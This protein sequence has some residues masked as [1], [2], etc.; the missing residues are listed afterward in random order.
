MED[1]NNLL[2]HEKGV[3]NSGEISKAYQYDPYS[4]DDRCSFVKWAGSFLALRAAHKNYTGADI[5]PT[6]EL[7]YWAKQTA[8]YRRN[9]VTD[10]DINKLAQK[11][12]DWYRHHGKY[13][14]NTM[15]TSDGTYKRACPSDRALLTNHPNHARSTA[16]CRQKY[17]LQES[18]TA[19]LEAKI[20]V[21]DE[22][23]YMRCEQLVFAVYEI[24]VLH[25]PKCFSL[26]DDFRYSPRYDENEILEGVNNNSFFMRALEAFKFIYKIQTGKNVGRTC[27]KQKSKH[28]FQ[29]FKGFRLDVPKL[30]EFL[31]LIEN[32]EKRKE[33]VKK[34]S[35]IQQNS[36]LFQEHDVIP[37][38]PATELSLSEISSHTSNSDKFPN[39]VPE[40]TNELSTSHSNFDVYWNAGRDLSLYIESSVHATPYPIHPT[41]ATFPDKVETSDVF[42]PNLAPYDENYCSNTQPQIAPRNCFRFTEIGM[43]VLKD[44]KYP[45]KFYKMT[46]SEQENYVPTANWVW[47]PEENQ[48]TAEDYLDLGLSVPP[49]NLGIAKLVWFFCCLVFS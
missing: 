36:Q 38:N 8:L 34:F 29:V 14:N 32:D 48:Y 27:K 33:L 18:A 13:V 28:R 43:W 31:D 25:D 45:K 44:P 5:S 10:R 22:H 26:T 17:A 40:C 9:K 24:L 1:Y 20:I 47:Q 35:D 37:M 4:I 11:N 42:R 39:H 46:P 16:W 49:K 7:I 21:E 41:L 3:A 23:S 19:L 2:P 12:E 15:V 30:S 6:A